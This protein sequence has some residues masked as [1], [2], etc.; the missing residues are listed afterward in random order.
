MP[1]PMTRY[2]LVL[3]TVLALAYLLPAA[4]D[5]VFP[6][7]S[8]NPLLLY[9]PVLNQFIYQ[10]SLGNHQFHYQDEAGRTYSRSETPIT[11]ELIRN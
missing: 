7:H 5:T 8:T 3:L 9:S 4:F 11:T 6:R 1:G 10:E 2:S